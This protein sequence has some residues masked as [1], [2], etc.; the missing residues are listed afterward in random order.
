MEDSAAKYRAS[1]FY[2]QN[3]RKLKAKNSSLLNCSMTVQNNLEEHLYEN[4]NI[5]WKDK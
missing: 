3:V 2:F 1:I 4:K 5:K